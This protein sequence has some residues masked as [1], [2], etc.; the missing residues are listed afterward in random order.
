MKA[1]DILNTIRKNDKITQVELAEKLKWKSQQQVS[2]VLNRDGSMRVD[3]FV[4]MLSVMG[5]EVIVRKNIGKSEE[6][7]VE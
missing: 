4:E 1:K 5:Y 3:I 7:R 6:W 2:Q